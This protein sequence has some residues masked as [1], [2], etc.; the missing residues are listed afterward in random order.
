MLCRTIIQEEARTMESTQELEKI[1]YQSLNDVLKSLEELLDTFHE[2]DFQEEMSVAKNFFTNTPQA[3][4]KYFHMWSPKAFKCHAIATLLLKMK[5]T[6]PQTAT[7]AILFPHAPDKEKEAII[8]AKAL[9][10]IITKTRKV[11]HSTDRQFTTRSLVCLKEQLGYEGSIGTFIN[12][13]K[14]HYKGTNSFPDI[15]AFSK[16]SERMQKLV[17]NRNTADGQAKQ[18]KLQSEAIAQAK[19]INDLLT[20]NK[21]LDISPKE[22]V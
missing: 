12:F 8:V 5:K 13:L 18:A 1:Y 7:T 3:L 17:R 20:R 22:A 9:D 4:A 14:K 16:D 21:T 6:S 10:F 19:R 11:N 2:E 15:S